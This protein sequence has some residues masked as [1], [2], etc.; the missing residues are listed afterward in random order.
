MQ[1]I[2]GDFPKARGPAPAAARRLA[3]V[4]L[5]FVMALPVP[6]Q[7]TDA[8]PTI[9]DSQLNGAL[10]AISQQLLSSRRGGDP[11]KSTGSLRRR[12]G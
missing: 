8:L 6:L 4:S 12:P 9:V 11:R 10:C 1:G 3:D 7:G 5:D 2:E